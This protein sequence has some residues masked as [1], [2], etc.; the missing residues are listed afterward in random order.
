M[1]DRVVHEDDV[2]DFV[3]HEF[4]NPASTFAL[5]S[6][7]VRAQCPSDGSIAMNT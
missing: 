5:A 7:G 2:A 4:R 3:G 6:C 1:P